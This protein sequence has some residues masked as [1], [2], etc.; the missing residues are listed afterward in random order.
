MKRPGG[1]KR[2]GTPR[3]YAHAWSPNRG[4]EVGGRQFAKPTSRYQCRRDMHISQ[5]RGGVQWCQLDQAR[6]IG[7]SVND[8]Q[9]TV[10]DDQK[11]AKPTSRYQC[12][13]DMHISQRRGG[14]QWRQLDQ[15]RKIGVS[16]CQ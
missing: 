9:K 15:A 12:R 10:V 14:V 1:L 13:R 11:F 4:E 5:R 8:D 6:K 3:A 16:S 2:P 7:V